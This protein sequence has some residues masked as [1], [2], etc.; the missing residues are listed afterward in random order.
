M[1]YN[2]ISPNYSEMNSAE[3]YSH[4]LDTEYLQCIEE[5]LDIADFEGLFAVV[6][7]LPD[8]KNREQVAD[9]LFDYI[10]NADIKSDYPYNEP[11][12]FP[13]IKQLCD[14]TVKDEVRIAD[15]IES[16]I[17]GAWYGRIC[18]CLLG[19]TVEGIRTD[20][21]YPFLKETNNY[22][23][24]RYI[25]S[26]DINDEIC[27]KYKFGFCHRCYADKIDGMPV[28]DDTN[29]TVFYQYII[30]KYGREFT[31]SDIANEWLKNQTKETYFTAE[32][33]AYF[34][35]IKGYLPPF[36]AICKNPYREWIGAQ[37][38]GDYFGYIN[39]GK[40]EIAAEMAYRDACISH[41][42]NGI[43]GEMFAAAI[44]A[45]AAVNDDMLCVIKT[46]LNNIPSTSRFYQKINYIIEMYNSGLSYE[47]CIACIHNEFNEHISHHWCH[48]IPN[49]MIVVAALLY[50]EG[51]YGK[52][53][54]FAV[55]AGF[56][57][58][59]NG[60]TV[61]SVIGIMKGRGAIGVE[62]TYPLNDKLQTYMY[63]CPEVSIKECIAKTLK[64]II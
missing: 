55:E 28:D 20:E 31:S 40:P 34:N 3:I 16:R 19:K 14:Y 53:I 32:R 13:E 12:V 64:H 23:L 11:S 36:S 1:K 38:R 22:P 30:D 48:T 9:V 56:D 45:E 57:T 58:D 29:Y 37:I 2:K 25:L 52:T 27:N 21:F 42:K 62:W 26:T 49:A 17:A 7:K 59:C 44:I 47:E 39:P 54:C 41:V 61:G 15:N 33:V 4:Q 43:Y 24:S 6:E 10:S 50:G 60:A 51:D 35:F 46:G 18:G 8:G 5:G 63:I